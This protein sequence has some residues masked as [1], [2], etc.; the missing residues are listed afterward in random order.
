MSKEHHK[1][2][3]PRRTADKISIGFFLVFLLVFLILLLPGSSKLPTT[4]TT[5][6]STLQVI[7]GPQ[8][9]IRSTTTTNKSTTDITPSVWVSLLGS[10]QTIFLISGSSLLAAYL[11]AALAQRIM[12]GRYA[13]SVGPL[14]VPEITPEQVEGYFRT[15]LSATTSDQQMISDANLESPPGPLPDFPR[16]LAPETSPAW[17]KISDPNLALAGWRIDLERQL[18]R[19]AEEFHIPGSDQRIIRRMVSSLAD[20]EIISHTVANSLQDLL[21]LAN[22]GVHGAKVDDGVLDVL[23]AD[24]LQLLEYLE[25]V[26]G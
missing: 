20:R 16:T 25:S 21:T 14:S 26:R 17:A 3:I 1:G 6:T 23:R 18:R 9:V 11:I 5:T 10:R 2:L 12:L 15:A 13:I 19:I 8:G 22:Q 24:G 4:A 7:R